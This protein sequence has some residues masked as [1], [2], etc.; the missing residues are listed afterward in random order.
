MVAKNE[1]DLQ[2]PNMK[3]DL[4]LCYKQLF[5]ICKGERGPLAVMSV[6]PRTDNFDMQFS[7]AFDELK[8]FR[9]A[10]VEPE[11]VKRL[12]EELIKLEDIGGFDLFMEWVRAVRESRM[13]ICDTAEERT[14]VAQYYKNLQ[15]RMKR[16]MT[17]DG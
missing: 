8:A 11:T 5:A 9:E 2:Y 16:G 3:A 1:S 12:V 7:A 14:A 6:P 13:V 10:G 4:E 15:D 17:S